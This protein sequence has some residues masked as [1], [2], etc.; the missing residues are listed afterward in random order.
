M[1]RLLVLISDPELRQRCSRL[2]AI[3]LVAPTV[4]GGQGTLASV[5]QLIGRRRPL[6]S[7]LLS[8]MVLRRPH[9]AALQAS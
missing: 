5:L 2:F 7:R 4:L 1:D 3:V 8:F 6:V 9:F